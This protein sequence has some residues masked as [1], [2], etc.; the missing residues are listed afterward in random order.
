ML[1]VWMSGAVVGGAVVMVSGSYGWAR[2]P[3]WG[4]RVADGG[5][6]RLSANLARI[7]LLIIVGMRRGVGARVAQLLVE[8]IMAGCSTASSVERMARYSL[9]WTCHR[10]HGRA[11][12][13]PRA[14]PSRAIR[15]CAR[16]QRNC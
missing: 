6:R 11:L 16:C 9:D 10:R 1:V 14:V 5:R 4:T 7:N 12:S 13:C 3:G 15:L 8:V 2:M